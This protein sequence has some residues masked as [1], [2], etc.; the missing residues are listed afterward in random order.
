MT[1]NWVDIPTDSLM[2]ADLI[3]GRSANYPAAGPTL[4]CTI[5]LGSYPS[6]ARLTIPRRRDSLFRIPARGRVLK[7]RSFAVGT[8]FALTIIR[9]ARLAFTYHASITSL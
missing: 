2:V 5:A 7:S 1:L 3:A 4:I 6:S 8:T 9:L